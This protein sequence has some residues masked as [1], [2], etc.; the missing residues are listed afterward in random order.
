MQL[1]RTIMVA[2]F[3]ATAA[4]QAPARAQD[5]AEL[6]LRIDRME[7]ENRRLNGQVEQ[8]GHQVRRLEDQLKRFQ[9][10]VDFRFKEGGGKG[11]TSSPEPAPQ[12]PAPRRSDAFDPAA[13]PNAPGAPRQI[14]SAAPSAPAL[15]GGAI[16]AGAGGPTSL[17][18]GG[19][20]PQPAMPSAEAGTPKGDLA[21]AQAMLERGEL[22]AAE[23]AYRDFVRRYP[24]D[25]LKSEA[26]FGL[27]ESFF[28]RNRYREAAEHYLTV[29]TDHA[30]SSRAAEAMLKLG[31]SLRG[32]GATAE[33]CGT[34]G[35]VAKKYPKASPGIRQAVERE[36]KRAQ[37]AA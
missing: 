7:A 9:A 34:Y 18:P 13:H 1:M 3:M 33:A 29:T 5:A 36:K 30:R 35:E 28:R 32:L 2:G 23:M 37:C 25:R 20:A 19:A 15:P 16:P 14:G 17:Q 24:K 26:V 8:L 31:M 10:D 4:A 6:M 12:T 27:G 11:A 21:V 22:E